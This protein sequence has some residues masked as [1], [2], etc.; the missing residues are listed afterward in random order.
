M[1]NYILYPIVELKGF[2]VLTVVFLFLLTVLVLYFMGRKKAGLQA[3]RWQAVF[4]GRTKRQV[5]WM[6]LGISQVVIVLSMVCFFVPMGTV[7]IAALALL[8]VSKGILGLSVTGFAGELVFGGLT[9]AALM[10]GNLLMDYMRE[11]GVDIY[12]LLV[13]A[14]LSLFVIQYGV[15][16]FIK[17]LE[18][19]LQQHERAKQRQEQRQKPEAEK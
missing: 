1:S 15:Y 18:R 5:L 19:M 8:C 13:W 2:I 10:A 17:G 9:G 12:I 7:Q 3:F 16:F 14:M 11:T 4:L 6:S